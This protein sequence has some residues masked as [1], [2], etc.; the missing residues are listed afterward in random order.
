MF[1]VERID[2]SWRAAEEPLGSKAKFW[3]FRE[4]RQF[5]F[6]AEERGTGEDW[7]KV[8]VCHLCKL[9]GLPHVHYELAEEYEGDSLIWPGVICETCAPG[10]PYLVLGNQLLFARDSNYPRH[11]DRKYKVREHTITAVA[12]A[13]RLLQLP[14]TPWMQNV[15]REIET[16]LDVFVGYAMLD[17]W[18][19]NQDRHHEN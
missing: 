10:P 18:L 3:F 7:A 2:R 17:A 6:K 15:P 13:M 14:D 1:A 8:A 11:G 9:L 19:A 12:D 5:L 16:A 4:A